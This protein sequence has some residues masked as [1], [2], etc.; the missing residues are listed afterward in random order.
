M[1]SCFVHAPCMIMDNVRHWFRT[2]SN[3][4]AAILDL[5]TVST[6]AERARILKDVKAS[7]QLTVICSVLE[8][9]RSWA[10][11]LN[12]FAH[13]K[14]VLAP[15]G[16]D[17]F[18]SLRHALRD[19]T[20]KLNCCKDYDPKSLFDS[21]TTGEISALL[22]GCVSFNLT[23]FR[24]LVAAY[25]ADIRTA[26]TAHC[27]DLA[28]KLD[29][30][31]MS[32]WQLKKENILDYQD[33]C[34][35]LVLNEDHDDLFAGEKELKQW[36]SAIAKL[37]QDRASVISY[38]Q[39][40]ILHVARCTPLFDRLDSAVCLRSVLQQCAYNKLKRS[41]VIERICTFEE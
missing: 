41:A 28:S 15:E 8:L 11:C 17:A 38:F 1:Q 21:T 5:N 6:I 27:L 9:F 37:Q 4:T 13:E 34:T 40:V 29:R 33:L 3:K 39:G 23:D 30:W 31:G 12:G 35:D 2:V 16:V 22:A 14:L 10:V 7:R 19:V 25:Q 24:D 32:G 36:N 18:S 26:W 20:E